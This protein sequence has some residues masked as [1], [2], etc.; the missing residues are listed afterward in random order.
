VDAFIL[1]RKRGKLPQL[2]LK[3][4]GGCGPTDESFV[5][6]LKARL[7]AEG[8]DG[9]AEFHPNLD[10]AAKVDFLRSLSV[11]SVPSKYGEA[12]GMY[13]IEALACGVPVVEPRSGA[14]TE[15][16]EDTGGGVLCET[17]NAQSLAEAIESVL[18]R[19]DCGRSLGEAGR[20]AVQEKFS[21]EA[22]ARGM[23]ELCKAAIGKS[24]VKLSEIPQMK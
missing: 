14:F 9:A 12:F 6:P 13:V 1:L 20:K 8:L 2:R 21:A 7:K 24:L 23:L 18:L 16:I 19:P 3:V 15:L 5:R 10:R 17:G 11:F 4:G 22:M